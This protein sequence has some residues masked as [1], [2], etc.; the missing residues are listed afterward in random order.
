M[1]KCHNHIHKS[2][3]FHILIHPLGWVII[4]SD[5]FFGFKFK[6]SSQRK[7]KWHM[8]KEKKKKLNLA[9]CFDWLRKFWWKA[10]PP[11]TRLKKIATV[12]TPQQTLLPEKIV[13]TETKFWG[14]C[15]YTF[16]PTKQPYLTFI[17]MIDDLK[18]SKSASL[19]YLSKIQTYKLKRKLI[20]VN[21]S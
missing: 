15:H 2:K 1:Q 3:T 8:Q 9:I 14:H 6:L 19:Q 11:K 4:K 17:T 13:H 5:S 18:S 20:R 7:N 16:S 12:S 21:I 10:L